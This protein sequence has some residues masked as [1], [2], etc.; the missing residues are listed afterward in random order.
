MTVTPLQTS[1]PGLAVSVALILVGIAILAVFTRQSARRLLTMLGTEA[2]EASEVAPGMVELEGTVGAAGETFDANA[3]MTSAEAVVIQSRQSGGQNN[4]GGGVPGVGL[5]IPQQLTPDVLN[6]VS[7]RPF[8]LEDDSGRILVDAA[9][10]D[11]SLESDYSRHD[12]LTD[13]AEVEAWL[14]PGDEVYVLG[15]AVPAEA[16][17]ERATP[18]GGRLRRV[19]HFLKADI[20]RTAEDA[21]D[22]GE[23]VVTHTPQASQFVVSDTTSGRSLLRQG[24]MTAFWTGAGLLAIGIGLNVFVAAL[25]L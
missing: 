16:Y 1:G 17:P 23:L 18:A 22:E 25:G 5:P 14:E 7:A 21:V 15:E 6:D 3:G 19:V 9:N 20:R 10:A 4:Q 8:Y 2:S 12:E 11:V 24:L 13:H